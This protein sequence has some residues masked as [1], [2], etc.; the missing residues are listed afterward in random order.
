MGSPTMLSWITSPSL[1]SRVM[2]PPSFMV[3]MVWRTTF[4]S[5]NW[6][7]PLVMPM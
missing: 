4:F 6:S 2:P 1:P 5:I 7:S 3:A